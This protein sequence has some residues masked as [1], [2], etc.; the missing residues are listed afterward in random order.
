MK[1]PDAPHDFSDLVNG[2]RPVVRSTPRHVSFDGGEQGH[3]AFTAIE[4]AERNRRRVAAYE[5]K[6]RIERGA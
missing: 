5:R 2:Q 3:H 1:L 6:Q 4:R